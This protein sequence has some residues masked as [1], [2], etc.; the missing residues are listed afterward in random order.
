[1][2]PIRPNSQRARY[3]IL[4]FYPVIGFSAFQALFFCWEYYWFSDMG[5]GGFGTNMYF[6]IVRLEQIFLYASIALYYLVAVFFIMWFRRAYYNLQA[7]NPGYASF[8]EGWAAGAWF[9]PIMNLF[10]P[11]QMMR[12]IWTGTQWMVPHKFPE[13]NPPT[14]VGYWWAAHISMIV[15]GY[16]TRYV[17]NIVSGENYL[18]TMS[19]SLVLHE[20]VAIAAAVLAIMMIKRISAFETALWEEAQSPSDSVFAITSTG[21]PPAAPAS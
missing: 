7:A 14:L 9:V 10:R 1:M 13:A 2:Y 3:A 11:F 15:M 18:I 4:M 20:L 6:T 16:I 19:T 5:G 17:G 12:E 8:S 21:L